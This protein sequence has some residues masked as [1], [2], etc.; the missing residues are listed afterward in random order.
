MFLHFH[1]QRQTQ[2]ALCI[3]KFIHFGNLSLR[4]RIKGLPWWFSGVWVL[5]LLQGVWVLLPLQGVWVQSL[6]GEL[7]IPHATQ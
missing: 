3:L 1:V 5:F 2:D 6:V 7:K 4:K